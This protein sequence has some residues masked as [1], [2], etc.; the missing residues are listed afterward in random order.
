MLVS[1]LLLSIEK[2]KWVFLGT[3]VVLNLA[4]LP[5]HAPFES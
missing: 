4:H 5:N 1:L 2:D 3:K